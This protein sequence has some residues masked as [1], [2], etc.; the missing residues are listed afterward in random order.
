MEENKTD[1]DT[2]VQAGADC[3]SAETGRGGGGEWEIDTAGLQEGWDSSS[4]VLEAGVK[5]CSGGKLLS[6]E[7][8]RCGLQAR[9]HDNLSTNVPDSPI[10]SRFRR[11]I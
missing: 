5:G 7:Q 9:S 11:E 4:D 2:E 10:D 8:R 3:N 6:P 1:A